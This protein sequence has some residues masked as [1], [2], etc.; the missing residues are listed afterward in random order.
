M[1]ITDLINWLEEEIDKCM[2]KC[3]IERLKELQICWNIIEEYLDT[4]IK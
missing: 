4:K 2:T 3:N 1:E